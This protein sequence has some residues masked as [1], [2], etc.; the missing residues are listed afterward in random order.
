M[1]SCLVTDTPRAVHCPLCN[2]PALEREFTLAGET[3]RLVEC[4]C[5]PPDYPFVSAVT[6][7]VEPKPHPRA[8]IF[9]GKQ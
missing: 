7:T 6:L 3:V 5:V 9:R 2:T 8:V 1:R 4:P